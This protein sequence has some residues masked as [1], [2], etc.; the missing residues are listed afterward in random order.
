MTSL[1][2]CYFGNGLS[3]LFT[4]NGVESLEVTL[5]FK[6]PFCFTCS[7]SRKLIHC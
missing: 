6:C 7:D 3:T 2:N 1:P 5:N 4:E